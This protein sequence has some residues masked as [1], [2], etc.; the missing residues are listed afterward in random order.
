MNPY[1]L[2]TFRKCCATALA[3]SLALQP[4]VGSAVTITNSNLSELPL[5]G[6]S[7]VKPNIMMKSGVSIEAGILGPVGVRMESGWCSVFH[8]STENLMTGMSRA[9]TSVTTATM[10]AARSWSSKARQSAM[11]PR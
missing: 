2:S 5:Q 4:I 9:P 11:I 7:R 8:Q 1:R 10:R 3:F 6:I